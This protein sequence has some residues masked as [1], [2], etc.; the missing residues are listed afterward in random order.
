[1]EGFERTLAFIQKQEAAAEACRKDRRYGDGALCDSIAGL[2]RALLADLQP[3]HQGELQAE[4]AELLRNVR[5]DIDGREAV[6]DI[7]I[8]RALKRAY[9]D[10]SAI[11]LKFFGPLPTFSDQVEQEVRS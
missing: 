8:A 4:L 11:Y 5:R 3:G 9:N 6:G 10:L 1:M 7:A 2:G